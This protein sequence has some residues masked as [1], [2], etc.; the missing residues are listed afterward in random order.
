MTGQNSKKKT[1]ISVL[2]I[3]F[4]IQALHLFI[5]S[6]EA[7][8]AREIMNF[9]NMFQSFFALGYC[10]KFILLLSYLICGINML[11]FNKN[12]EPIFVKINII[13]FVISILLLFHPRYT[14]RIRPIISPADNVTIAV[15][16][17]RYLLNFAFPI[18]AHLYLRNR[19]MTGQS[20]RP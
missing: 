13:F 15:Y 2:T 5:I 7:I 1:I 3:A 4:S 12:S 19:N 17:I 9:F 10:L 20:S 14:G 8:Y 18:L 6:E 16:K 11:F